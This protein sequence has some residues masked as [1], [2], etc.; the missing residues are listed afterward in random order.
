VFSHENTTE[1]AV[2]ANNDRDRRKATHTQVE[3][4][5]YRFGLSKERSLFLFCPIESAQR[6]EGDTK[7]KVT[8]AGGKYPEPSAHQHNWEC[9]SDESSCLVDIQTQNRRILY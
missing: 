9:Y 6:R 3:G 2:A 1:E 8:Q 5:G 4:F 7:K